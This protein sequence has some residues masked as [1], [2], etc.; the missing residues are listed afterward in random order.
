MFGQKE[1]SAKSLFSDGIL[2]AF[3]KLDQWDIDGSP[4]RLVTQLIEQYGWNPKDAQSRVEELRA[5]L[6]KETEN[7]E[8]PSIARVGS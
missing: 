7:S 6:S 8:I 1:K 3:G 4:E 2:K 5:S